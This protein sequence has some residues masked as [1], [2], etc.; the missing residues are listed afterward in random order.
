[1]A[2]AGY[3]LLTSNFKEDR[4]VDIDGALNAQTKLRRRQRRRSNWATADMATLTSITAYQSW[5]C[6]TNNDNDYTQLDAIPDYG[7]CN[8]EHQ[9]SPG[10]ALL[11]ASG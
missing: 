4:Y 5:S 2:A 9:F 8:K 7:S 11:D 1:M 6:F 10:T 3:T